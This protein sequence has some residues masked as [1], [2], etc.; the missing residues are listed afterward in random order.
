VATP[1]QASGVAADTMFEHLSPWFNAALLVGAAAAVWSAGTRLARHA[2]D[3]AR[4]TGLGRAMLGM[5]LL[6]GV[7]SLPELAVAV[8][9]TLGGAPLL[10]VNDILGSA[11]INVLILALA[12]AAFGRGALTSTPGHPQVLLQGTLSVMLLVLVAAAV[13]AG[14]RL[15]LGIGAWSWL[16]LLGYAAAVRIVVRAGGQPSWLP[17]PAGPRHQEPPEA[18]APT[19]SRGRL[20]RRIVGAGAVIL[21]AGF[22]LAQAA[23]AI[24]VQTGLGTSFVGAVLL[25]LCTSLPEVSTALAAVRLGR[26]EMAIGDIFGTNLFNMTILVLIDALHPGPPV[27][28]IAGAFA[29]FAAAMAALMTLIFIVGAL[30]RR[31]RTLWRMG[32]DSLAVIAVYAVGVVVLYRLR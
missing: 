5:L 31:D 3:L 17:D 6:G 1:H 12:D 10:T 8:T 18:D 19:D 21:A 26:Y 28:Q 25:A 14:D 13:I 22:V 30:E 7:T 29:G 16:L 23:E 32:A 27:L 4:K 9:A 20:V 24:A 15:L 2:D 11:A